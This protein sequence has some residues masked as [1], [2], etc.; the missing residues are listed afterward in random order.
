VDDEL[1]VAVETGEDFLHLGLGDFGSGDGLADGLFFGEVLAQ[2]AGADGGVE[3]VE[4]GGFGNGGFV[5]VG[6]LLALF[7]DDAGLGAEA[8]GFEPLL[9]G[10]VVSLGGF[11]F[12]GSVA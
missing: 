6:G 10:G 1:A 2:E 12:D 9:R 4:V 3:D 7:V 8:G 5:G 11:L